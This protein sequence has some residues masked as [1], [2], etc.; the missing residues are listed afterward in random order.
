V[1]GVYGAGL[2]GAGLGGCVEAIVDDG[3]VDNLRNA[4]ITQYFEKHG[5]D[6]FIEV[7][8]PVEGAC[9]VELPEF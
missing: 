2:I 9:A 5:R 3:A 8:A 1:D 4:L 6:P 7:M